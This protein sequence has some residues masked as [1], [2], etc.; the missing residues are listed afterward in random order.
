MNIKEAKEEIRN[1]IF[2][3]FTKDEF[4][5][6]EIP[7]ERQR[8]LFLMGPPGIGKTAIMEQISQE[9][10][11][12]LVSYSMSHHTRQS[13]LGLPFITTKVYDGKE[14]SVSEYTMSEIIASVY[15]MIDD[16]G[17]KE[18]I[19]FLD[20]VNCVSETLAPAMLQFLQYKTFGK[21]R[22]P[23][24]WIVVTAGNPPEYNNSVREMDIV[25]WDR[26]KRIDIEPDY[27][28]W[29]EY[30]VNI[31]VHPAITTY[32]DIKKNDFYEVETT[33]DGKTFVTARGWVDLSAMMR[34]YERRGFKIT[35]RLVRQYLQNDRIARDF[36]VYYDLFNK[37]RSDYQVENILGGELD[38]DT[39][40]RAKQADPDERLSLLGLILD[41]L[42]GE[43][44]GV[45]FD[46]DALTEL[47]PLLKAV[48][49]AL[50]EGAD[51]VSA[52]QAQTDE[53]VRMI[54]SGK[55]ASTLSPD[56]QY[57]LNSVL[58]ILDEQK[59]LFNG[60]DLRGSDAFAVIKSDF[61]SRT[62]ALK[63]EARG[64][65]SRLSNVFTF[66]ETMF[67]M[68]GEGNSREMIILVTE[69]TL[70]N[71]S[72]RFISRYGCDKYFA[73]SDQLN[74][75]DRQK[76]LIDELGDLDL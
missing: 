3:Y 52:L 28:A 57:T 50:D 8:P 36:A 38:V 61:A 10:G 19:L 18:G 72:A 55:R 76:E 20:E 1:A 34:I 22:I 63:E 11:V 40:T 62:A 74:F 44:K 4:G 31:G 58:Q 45:C 9:L 43:L 26:M 46:E 41:T 30:A 60:S 16:T 23:Q 13:A 6:Y 67:G 56:R 66:C 24:G 37:Y 29:K 73:H 7:V 33:A 47:V 42:G 14:Y 35:E 32:L 48:K 39:K 65:G 17:L 51:P 25:T 2:A 5:G 68:D 21:H 54:E 49:A 71:Y 27:A 53:I 64:A 70:N 75:H 69:L 15:D 12:G 59:S